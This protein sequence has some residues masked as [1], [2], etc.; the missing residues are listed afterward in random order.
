MNSYDDETQWD[1]APGDVMM[2][3]PTREFSDDVAARGYYNSMSAYANTSV[4]AITSVYA[5]TSAAEMD[6]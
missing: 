3:Q 6:A 1:T 4:Y 2:I 5:G